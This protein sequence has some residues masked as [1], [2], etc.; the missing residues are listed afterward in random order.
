MS[1]ACIPYYTKRDAQQLSSSSV[2]YG[3]FAH[4]QPNRV[5][6]VTENWQWRQSVPSRGPLS[7]IKDKCRFLN[8]VVSG[9]GAP[10]SL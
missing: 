10:G 8:S 2:K 7:L 5:D 1:P 9:K 3:A 4:M 6:N